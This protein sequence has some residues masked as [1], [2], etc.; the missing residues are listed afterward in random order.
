MQAADNAASSVISS[1]TLDEYEYSRILDLLPQFGPFMCTEQV[2]ESKSCLNYLT[3]QWKLCFA[4]EHHLDL[5]PGSTGRNDQ[6]FFLYSS[7]GLTD[8]L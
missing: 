6:I 2:M 1:I 5:I 4:L 3:L 8:S 7:F